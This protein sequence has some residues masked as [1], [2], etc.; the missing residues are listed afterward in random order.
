MFEDEMEEEFDLP[1]ASPRYSDHDRRAT[2]SR[3]GGRRL[4]SDDEDSHYRYSHQGE[5]GY[6]HPPGVGDYDDDFSEEYDENCDTVNVYAMVRRTCRTKD[7]Y[8]VLTVT[9]LA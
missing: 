7:V 3:G 6:H 4:V 9:I 1:M 2:L 8:F 5:R